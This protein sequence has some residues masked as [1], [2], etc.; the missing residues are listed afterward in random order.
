[1]NTLTRQRLLQA[2]ICLICLVLVS[3]EVNIVGP[4]EFSGGRITGPLFRAADLGW[5]VFALGLFVAIRYQRTASVIFLVASLLCFPMFSY[6]VIPGYFAKFFHAESSN[7]LEAN[8]NWDA[9]SVLTLLGLATAFYLGI[10]N[11]LA[12]RNPK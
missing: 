1:M 9:W 8:V 10:R 2:S 12:Y 11:L 6:F 4:T 5:L 7:P 3:R